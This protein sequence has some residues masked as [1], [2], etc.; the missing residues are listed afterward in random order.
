MAKASAVVRN[1]VI[2]C[3]DQLDHAASAFDG[4]DPSQ[5]AVWMAEV[6]HEA[7]HV[8]CHKLRLACFFAAMRH[9]REELKAGGT[10]VHYHELTEN[11]SKDRGATFSE[12]LA[13]DHGLLKPARLVITEPGDHRVLHEFT[14]TARK[15]K[16]PIDVRPD[17]H[18]Y[19]TREE[20]AQYARG[21]KSLLLEFFYRDQRKKHQVLMDGRQPVGGQWNF[22]HDNRESFGKSGPGPVPQPMAFAPDELTK[23]VIRMVRSRYREHPGSLEHLTLPINRSQALAFLK[24]FIDQV[25]P[26]FGQWEDAMWSEE[27]FLYHSRLSVP[28]N[29]KLL[30]PRECV[31]AAVKAYEDGAAPLNS[32]EGFIRQIL[33]WREFVRGVYWLKMPEYETL[34]YFEHTLPMPSF[35]WDGETEMNCVR[36][37]MQHVLDHGYS[38]HIHRLM[39]LGN[40][41]QLWGAHPR[42]FHEWHMAMYVDAIDW[43]SLPNTLG[44]SQFG[45]GGIVG[46]KPY[47]SSGNYIN[48][49]SNF[50]SG[51][52]FDYRRRTGADACP[53][54][55]L[56]WEF[57][58]RHYDVLKPNVRMKFPIATLEKMRQDPEEM[59]AIHD[60]AAQLR[61][62][63]G[64]SPESDA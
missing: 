44:M 48:K 38:H 36:Q 10:T 40:F 4:F 5:D 7:T 3:G 1:L 37:S 24:N 14:E 2:I 55:T 29:L 27:A 15:L 61:Q 32:V 35:F 51:C 64:Q 18:F 62:R 45:D 50:C 26:Q 6:H 57:M 42:L 30:N 59:K 34:N 63:W 56:Y 11:A 58:D 46:T 43:V 21:K 12:I 53:F 28:L 19:C 20:F 17:R 41:A 54:T 47:C 52:R 9:F 25:L 22:D 8:W 23:S 33:G 60:R 49:M 39:V 13:L 16:T 31:D